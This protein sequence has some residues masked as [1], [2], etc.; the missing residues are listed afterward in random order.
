LTKKW[1]CKQQHPIHT[2]TN[3]AQQISKQTERK[4]EKKKPQTKQNK[5]K[6]QN[7]QVNRQTDRQH[8]SSSQNQKHSLTHTHTQNKQQC[9]LVVVVFS[10]DSSQVQITNATITTVVGSSK[11]PRKCKSRI[12]W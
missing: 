9:L 3:P 5:T 7:K 4:K 6:E 2:T 1:G 8:S 12:Q 10:T 11:L